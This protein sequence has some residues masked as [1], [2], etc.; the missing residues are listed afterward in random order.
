V[1]HKTVV[2]SRGRIHQIDQ[3]MLDVARHPLNVLPDDWHGMD[4]SRA[5]AAQAKPKAPKKRKTPKA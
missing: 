2:D 5:E 4:A 1:T 3:R